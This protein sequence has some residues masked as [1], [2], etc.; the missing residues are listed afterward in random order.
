MQVIFF[1]TNMDMIDELKSK[2]DLG[3]SVTCYDTD[4]LEIE[5]QKKSLS[6]NREII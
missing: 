6:S 2:T 4:S 1:S 3:Q 5:L